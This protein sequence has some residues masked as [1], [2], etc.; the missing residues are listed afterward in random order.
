MFF[1]YTA[2]ALLAALIILFLPGVLLT[3]L[4]ARDKFR[5]A[6]VAVSFAVGF[7][8]VPYLALLFAGFVGLVTRFH[9]S[10]VYVS[11]LSVA[12]SVS[13]AI[14]LRIKEGS[15]GYA[16]NLMGELKRSFSWPMFLY[17]TFVLIA[18]LVS[19][20]SSLFD[21]ERCVSRAGILPFFDYLSDNPPVGFPGC[22]DC[23]T[24]R[25]AFFLWN[26][27]QRMGPSVFVSGFLSLFG[28]PGLRILHAVFGLLTAWFGWHLG[29]SLFNRTG[30][31]VL[32]SMLVALNPYALSIPL[33]DEN[34]MGLALGTVMFFLMFQKPTQWIFVGAFLGLFLGI[35][36]VGL[37]SVPAVL[38][39]AWRSVEV[40]HYKSPLVHDMFGKGRT[41]NL[42]ILLL[43]LLF[44]CI[45]W[46]FIHTA[47]YLRGKDVYEAFVSMPALPH[48]F[49]GFDFQFNGLLSWPFVD[50][51]VR[52]PY[53]GFPTLLSFPLTIMKS[54][55]LVLMAFLPIG[56]IRGRRRNPVVATSSA[57]WLLPQMAMLMVMA[58]WVQPNKMGVFLTFSQPIALGIT[59]GVVALF[60]AFVGRE[61]N[62]GKLLSLKG[63]GI[64]WGG[65][66]AVLVVFHL[67]APGYDAQLDERNF[68]ARVEYILEDYPVTPPM[69]R[70]N[71]AKFAEADRRRLSRLTFAPD[72]AMSPHVHTFA[73]L[74]ARISQIV[75]D[76]SHP[77]FSQFTERPKDM[78]H[79]L[80]GFPNPWA[81]PPTIT[82]ADMMHHPVSYL[83]DAMGGKWGRGAEPEPYAGETAD[84]TFD[85][86]SPPIGGSSFLVQGAP[87]AFKVSV[88]AGWKM[89]VIPNITVPWADGHPAHVVIIPIAHGNY[90]MTVWFGKYMFDHLESRTDI[91][92]VEFPA[93]ALYLTLTL[94]ESSIIR[95]NEV[96]T[97]EP[98]RFHTWNIIV[99]GPDID[100]TG[101]FP[102][103]Y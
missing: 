98:T 66:L 84:V 42:S 65:M 88:S 60:D 19:Y 72:F 91:Q 69:V 92:L 18:Y 2:Y 39:V 73:L 94:P 97:I 48:S 14:G 45:P 67:T 20:D 25:N 24:E 4:L 68:T 23:F 87:A 81:P 75:T 90:W 33:L 93:N 101:P 40:E 21:Q 63:I 10:L 17:L 74:R 59:A 62:P 77:Y 30:P 28:F 51:P 15:F 83:R 50:S 53:N 103:S 76:F 7:L 13:A 80:A 9:E 70:S 35:R 55:G 52:S 100:V 1:A 95:F 57:L 58:N 46:I 86:A 37:L 44:F 22:V 31:A 102:S 78:I 49:L 27:G 61:D 54:W 89:V 85:L 36:H 47:G 96:T 82:Y 8:V 3:R 41:A 38:Y 11:A 56:L 16:A 32:L 71:E 12:V 6:F 26:G 43:S 34:I 79:G 5:G 64:I 99:D 29:L